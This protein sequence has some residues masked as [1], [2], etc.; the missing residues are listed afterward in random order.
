MFRTC[1][2]RQHSIAIAL[3]VLFTGV[4]ESHAAVDENRLWLPKTYTRL[5]S[6]L[7]LSAQAAEKTERCAEVIGGRLNIDQSNDDGAYFVI[8]CRDAYRR[9]YTLGYWSPESGGEPIKVREQAVTP[10]PE[11]M[12]ARRAKQQAAAKAKA[13]E[14]AKEQAAASNATPLPTDDPNW[15][16]HGWGDREWY[17][18]KE[19]ETVERKTDEITEEQR[20]PEEQKQEDPDWGL[21]NWGDREWYEIDDDSGDQPPALSVAPTIEEGWRLCE[22]AIAE[23]TALMLDVKVLNREKAIQEGVEVD[24]TVS[25]SVFVDAKNP[26]GVALKYMAECTVSLY[27]DVRVEL[28]PR[29]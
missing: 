28:R 27:R 11:E 5:Q 21:D 7:L 18:L 20:P 14:A 10:L 3:T 17:E 25:F 8:T 12:A 19:G 29:K 26:I 13:E 16:V 1:R 24:D 4:T 9:S 22:K 6:R 2:P 23:K 15:G